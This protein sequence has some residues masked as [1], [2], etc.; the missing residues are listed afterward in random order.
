MSIDYQGLATLLAAFGTLAT[1][2]AN[3]WVTLRGQAKQQQA[4]SEM[5][6]ATAANN[7]KLIE[8]KATTDLTHNLINGQSEKL[9]E[10]IRQQSLL[11]GKAAGILEERANPM[12]PRPKAKDAG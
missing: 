1:V 3:V 12:Q 4:T 8:V 9:N 6:A 11:V 5:K 10:S 7:E 2:L